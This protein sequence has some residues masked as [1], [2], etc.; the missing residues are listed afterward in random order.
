VRYSYGADG[1]LS[2][3]IEDSGAS[4]VFSYDV[5]GRETRREY[6]NGI[7]IETGYDELGR[8]TFIRESHKRTGEITRAKGYVYD[9]RGRLSATIDERARV[10]AYRYDE[11]GRLTTALYP[12]EGG[13]KDADGAE[14]LKLGV[15]NIATGTPP[16]E[17][18][19]PDSALAIALERALALAVVGR[20]SAGV[21]PRL[22][23]AQR[24]SYDNNGNRLSKS[25]GYGRI[26]YQYGLEDELQRASRAFYSYDADGRLKESIDLAASTKYD[27]DARGRALSVDIASSKGELTSLIY[28]YDAL[29]RRVMRL[30]AGVGG[31]RTLYDGLGFDHTMS[32]NLDATGSRAT[33]ASKPGASGKYDGKYRYEG[34]GASESPGASA[35]VLDAER[36]SLAVKGHPVAFTTKAGSYYLGQDR[37]GSTE[38]ISDSAGG[39]FERIEYDAFGSIVTGAPEAASL[40]GYAGKRYDPATGS[41]DYGFRDYAPSQGR[42]TSV[43][44]IRDGA[45]WYGYCDADPV[46]FVDL[47]GLSAS[48]SRYSADHSTSIDPEGFYSNSGSDYSSIDTRQQ[49]GGYYAFAGA[50]LIGVGAAIAGGAAGAATET[51]AAIVAGTATTGAVV[52]GVLATGGCIMVGGAMVLVGIDLMNGNGLDQTQGFIDYLLGKE[53]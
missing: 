41:Y 37:L 4:V 6:G 44:P 46:N 1:E 43:D 38:S 24:Y 14:A 5:V 13:T 25:T 49:E 39:I 48:D 17:R 32:M 45:N 21:G 12:Y 52:A 20:K 53:E 16:A 51:V 23:W 27:Y 42:F 50:D 29:G 11:A 47:W 18:W 15:T 7:R 30:E 26:E 34:P 19:E 3:V 28:E 33:G 31:S 10:S 2:S 9:E 36:N 40:W 22:V 35:M 8:V